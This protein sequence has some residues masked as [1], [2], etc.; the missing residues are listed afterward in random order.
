VKTPAELDAMGP[1]KWMNGLCP[2]YA[3]ALRSVLGEGEFV[4]LFDHPDLPPSHVY[5]VHKALAYD[6]ANNGVHESKLLESRPTPGEFQRRGP[7]LKSIYRGLPEIYRKHDAYF[8]DG[9][10]KTRWRQEAE[11]LIKNNTGA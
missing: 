6:F 1:S 5:F 2:V 10:E 3:D 7:D 11:D 9:P 8:Y 4:G